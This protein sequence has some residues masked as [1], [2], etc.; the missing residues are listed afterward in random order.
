MSNEKP[1]ATGWFK[2][3]YSSDAAACVEIKFDDGRVLV[4]DSKY[5]GAPA[6]RPILTFTT[7]DW[8]VFLANL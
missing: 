6:A 4:R 7:A 8:S 3:S 5:Q 2:S 1:D